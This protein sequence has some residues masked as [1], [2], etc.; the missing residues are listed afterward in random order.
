MIPPRAVVFDLYGTLIELADPV[1]QQQ[2]PR[3]EAISRRAWV[4]MQRDLL[5][6][7]PFADSAAFVAAIL[8]RCGDHDAAHLAEAL[9]LLEREV[10]S[11]RAIE[12]ARTVLPFLRRRG[13]RLALIT[14]SASPYRRPL[15]DLGLAENFAAITFSCDAGAR[16][17]EPR[18]Y[19]ETL[20]RLGVPPAAALMVGDSPA[21]DVR[22]PEALGIRGLLVGSARDA[23]ALA[24]LADLGWI[25]LATRLPLC[26]VGTRL[27]VGGVAGA[28]EAVEPLPDADQGRYNLV[29][30]ARFV[31]DDGTQSVV[32]L[33]RFLL[34]ESVEVERFASEL[35]AM[36]GVPTCPHGVIAGAE[37]VFAVAAAPGR[38]LEEPIPTAG[39]AREVGRHAAVAYLFANA[40]LRPRNAFI[41]G[42][43]EA[44]TLLMLDYEHCLLNLAIDLEGL[45]DALD[46]AVFAALPAVELE[47]RVARK[48]LADAHMR[49]AYRAFFGPHAK[50]P[51]LAQAFRDGWR[52]AHGQV[53]SRRDEVAA[54]LRARAA[55]SPPLV[56]GTH[57]YRRAFLP[58][59]VADLLARVDEDPD[60]ACDRCF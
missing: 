23:G 8:E 50:D 39:Y 42:P 45:A 18:L 33:K 36:A 57:A 59:D 5:L 16:K 44:P 29:A 13:L 56:V 55:A 58:L 46:P 11:A 48:V 7:R 49:R 41:A 24:R 35:V 4:E 47:R 19:L 2:L 22:A 28:L 25:D 53:R 17:P 43:D 6:V 14:N 31:A 26:P 32:Y 1:F 3:L 52:D 9:A 12:G 30:R 21:N 38:K 40:D 51:R 34:P 37:P 27:A 60:R 10:A 15:D 54:R 20:D